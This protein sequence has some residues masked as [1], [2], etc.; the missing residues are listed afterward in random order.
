LYSATYLVVAVVK[1]FPDTFN[2][3]AI[4]LLNCPANAKP[5][6]PMY[7]AIT[8]LVIN[9]TA[10]L[11]IVEIADKYDVFRSVIII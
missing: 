6:G 4:K 11:I 7:T 1:A 9:P 5:D 8:L 2:V 3:K 10:I